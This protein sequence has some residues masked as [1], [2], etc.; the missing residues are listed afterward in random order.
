MNLLAVLLVKIQ[1]KISENIHR[2]NQSL[3]FSYKSAEA[4]DWIVKDLR[5]TK[6]YYRFNKA[7]NNPLKPSKIKSCL[8]ESDT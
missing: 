4:S 7:I 3:I 2:L 6:F 8:S 5:L 1:K